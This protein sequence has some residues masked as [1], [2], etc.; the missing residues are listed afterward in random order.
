MLLSVTLK[1]KAPVVIVIILENLGL[2]LRRE[3][4][5][6]IDANN[7]YKVNAQ[8]IKKKVQF[9]SHANTVKSFGTFEIL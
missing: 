8:G 2:V 4:M 5:L 1:S 3:K 7:D 6:F 9:T